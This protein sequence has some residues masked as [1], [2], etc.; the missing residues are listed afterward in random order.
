MKIC[1]LTCLLLTC[2]TCVAQK[3]EAYYDFYWKTCPA[4]N[5]SYYS[6]VE[7]TDSGWLRNDY[8]LRAQ[9]LQMRALYEDEACKIQNGYSA[10]YYSNGFPSSKGRMEHGKQEGVCLSYSPNGMVTDSAL[11]RNGQVVDKRFR[12]HSNG[13]MSDSICRV[14]DSMHV[15]IGWFDDGNLAYAGYLLYGKEHGKWKYYHRNGRMSAAEVYDHGKIDSAVYFDENGVILTDTTGVNQEAKYPA[16]ESAW[17]LYLE[18]KLVW[19]DGLHFTTAGWVTIGVDFVVDEN[20]KVTDA[21]VSLPL[22]E[23]FDKAVL[24][25]ISNSPAWQPAVAHNRKVKAWRRQPFTF[26]QKE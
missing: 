17:R 20:G 16:G 3:T 21:R 8:Y 1:Q 13:Y 5:A 22:H 9:R 12:W 10:Y 4:E 23:A 6:I 26:E 24:K 18:K 14:N 15:Q 11:F 7:K 19:P 25:V 2:Y